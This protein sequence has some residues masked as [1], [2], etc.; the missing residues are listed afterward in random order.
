[1]CGR[2]MQNVEAVQFGAVLRLDSGDTGLKLR[3]RWN[4][5]PTQDFA[6]CRADSGGKRSLAVQRWGL[7]PAWATDPKVGARLINARSETVDS[8]SAFRKSFRDRRCLIPANGWFE[9]QRTA[10]GR[11]PWWI[12]SA[13]S[14]FCFAGLWD[15]WGVGE[16]RIESFTI[17]TCPAAESLRE[18]HHRQPAVVP[19]AL[20]RTWLDPGTS[21]SDLL[22]LAQTPYAGPFERWTVGPEVNSVK[23]DYP[24]IAQRAPP[25]APGLFDPAGTA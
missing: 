4:G 11:Q 17:L 24:E 25:G 14:P 12:S 15:V 18:I 16:R 13:D 19:A 5:A 10:A 3:S 8:K 23:N 1:M 2:F 7:V 22:E 21:S 9:W 20:Y 6:V